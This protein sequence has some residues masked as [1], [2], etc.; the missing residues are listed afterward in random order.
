MCSILFFT[1]VYNS[2]YIGDP[3]HSEAFHINITII[4]SGYDHSNISIV[5]FYDITLG[6]TCIC[7]ENTICD[8]FCAGG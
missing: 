5:L 2:G 7:S 4:T 8:R 1:F 6:P 3:F